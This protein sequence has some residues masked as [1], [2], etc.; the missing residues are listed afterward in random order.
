M[1]DGGIEVGVVE[2]ERECWLGMGVSGRVG[3]GV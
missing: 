2:V 3:G 1:G